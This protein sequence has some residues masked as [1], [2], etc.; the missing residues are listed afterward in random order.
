MLLCQLGTTK[1]LHS[2]TRSSAR[3]TLIR[4]SRSGAAISMLDQAVDRGVLMPMVLRLPGVSAALEPQKSRCSLPGDSDW[5]KPVDDHVEVELVG[6]A[7]WYCAVS[8]VRTFMS[9]PMRSR[10]CL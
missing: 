8:T 7:A 3:V 10:F 2:S 5:P 9:M 6:R 1:W 4:L